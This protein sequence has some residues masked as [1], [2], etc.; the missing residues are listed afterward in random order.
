MRVAPPEGGAWWPAPPIDRPE[1]Q[2]HLAG[3]PDSTAKCLR[4][5]YAHTEN[6]SEIDA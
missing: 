4:S 5:F 2:L 3:R 6:P 1:I